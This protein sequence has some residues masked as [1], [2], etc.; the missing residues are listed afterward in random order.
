MS[1]AIVAIPTYRR[2]AGLLQLL[3]SLAELSTCHQ[4]RI[5]VGDND[6]AQLEGRHVVETL[7]AEGYPWP[8][9][10]II[11]T[12]RGISQVR[13]A[14]IEAS[15]R[16]DGA[17]FVL[18]LDDDEIAAPG[19]LDEMIS[20]Q[21]ETGADIVGGRVNRLFE[22]GKPKW[23]DGASLLSDKT[24]TGL[25]RVDMIH[26]TCNTLFSG[27]FLRQQERPLFDPSFGLTGGEDKEAFTRLK[28]A[29]ATF[30]WAESAV[31]WE[32]I[33]A[34]RLTREWVLKRAFRVGNSDM[35]VLIRH[36]GSWSEV[37][38]EVLKALAVLAA[39]PVLLL[40][41]G[42]DETRDIRSRMMIWRAAGK[43]SAVAGRSYREY[44][45]THG[46]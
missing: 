13:N 12:A 28:R 37:G 25:A 38:V 44:L 43:L 5:I 34:S 2:P 41:A 24:H 36:H 11:V 40:R 9:E 20:R 29:G 32:Q 16:D 14:L 42:R 30:A 10:A 6:S 21:K 3:E 15:L 17:D 27:P 8:I 39:G 45:V 18:M 7:R 35:R 23:A 46:S 31:V 26:S 1:K 19:W 22:G 33:P 4:L